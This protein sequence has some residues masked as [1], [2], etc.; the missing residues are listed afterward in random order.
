MEL[1]RRAFTG[2]ALSLAAV[3]SPAF[4]AK[5]V[6]P[7]ARALAAIRAYADAH[8]RRFNLPGL[9]LGITSP[10]GFATVMNSGFANRDART[11]ITPDTL[12]QIGSISKNMVVAL[13]HQQAAEGRFRLDDNFARLMPDLPLPRDS[14][15]TVQHVIDHVAGLPGDAPLFPPVGLWIAYRPGEHWHYSNTGYDM[16]GKLAEHFGGKPLTQLLRE[17]LFAPLGMRNTHGAIL[18]ADRTRYAQGYEAADMTRPYAGGL[19]LAPAPWVDVT[20]GAGSIASTAEDINLYLRSLANAAQGRGGMGLDAARGRAFTS[21]FVPADT[22]AFSY[23]N[24]LMKVVEEG[25]T[26]LHHTGGMVAFSSAF[27]VDVASGVGAFASS[28][29]SGFHDYRPRLLSLFAV[30]ALTAAEAGKPVPSPPPLSPPLKN[31][32]DYLGRFSG[33]AGSFEVSGSRE[34]TLRSGGR[35]APLQAWGDD[36]FRTTHP[37]FGQ[38]SLLFERANGK[39]VGAAWG[40]L[41][42]SKQGT[43]AAEART[44]PRLARLAGRYV[45]DSPWIG[46][47]YVVERGGKLWL[48]TDTPMTSIGN[49]L[50]RVG[51]DSWS[52]ERASFANFIDGRPQS[53]FLSGN[54][55]LRHEI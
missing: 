21:H 54:E 18:G 32:G 34:L 4:A 2:G 23:G 20:F 51:E 49:N 24:G 11:P 14:V 8:R 47:V 41:A 13:I 29:V 37:A 36:L 39:V 44:N 12:F 46:L 31:A 19:P 28:T 52:P 43:A 7:A 50:W 3:G 5:P 1:T 27:H 53:L 42:F 55:F 10:S 45:N 22:P 9:T 38:F 25:R 35:E 15:F 30:K 6:S 40:P 17:R 16:L 48:G 33:P 26:Y